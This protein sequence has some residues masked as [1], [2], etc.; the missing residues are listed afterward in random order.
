MPPKRRAPTSLAV[1]MPTKALDNGDKVGV[2]FGVTLNMGDYQSLKIEAWA[3]G[4][5][6]E[7][8]TSKQAFRRLF[9]IV[10]EEANKK[11]AEYKR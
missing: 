6:R 8:E 11:A 4:T 10:E 1:V 9:S 7:G 5:K 3:E 2:S